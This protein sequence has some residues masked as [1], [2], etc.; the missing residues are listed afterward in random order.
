MQNQK[1]GYGG[2]LLPGE[3]KAI[4]SYISEGKRIPRRGEI[5]L[6]SEEIDSFEKIGFVMSGSRHSIMNAVRQRKEAQIFTFEESRA[7]HAFNMEKKLVQ[8]YKTIEILKNQLK[9]HQKKPK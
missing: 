3:G 4:A 7:L 9:D 1:Q 5:G 2:Q 6:T 8:E